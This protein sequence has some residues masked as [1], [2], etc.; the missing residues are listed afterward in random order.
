[1][2][3]LAHC[4]YLLYSNFYFIPIS[5]LTEVKGFDKTNCQ[6]QNRFN[7]RPFTIIAPIAGAS[8]QEVELALNAG[9]KFLLSLP[10]KRRVSTR[11]VLFA[12]TKQ[13]ASQLVKLQSHGLRDL[14]QVVIQPE[15]AEGQASFALQG[16]LLF[17]PWLHKRTRWI[18]M[19][20]THGLPIVTFDSPTRSTL[21][22]DSCAMFVPVESREQ[23]AEAFADIFRML[24]FD[25]GAQQALKRG[26]LRRYK[27]EPVQSGGG[28]ILTSAA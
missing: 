13:P 10:K 9:L 8:P 22:D 7:M 28:L 6:T 15:E 25:P 1:M 5:I 3:S 16:D 14:V 2:I 18:R 4:F 24:F 12:S 27:P 20:L 19:A 21:L 11:M 23:S 26:A 17:L